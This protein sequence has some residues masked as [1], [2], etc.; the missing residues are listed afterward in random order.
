M[1]IKKFS[2]KWISNE[3]RKLERLEPKVISKL[4]EIKDLKTRYDMSSAIYNLDASDIA[5]KTTV[6]KAQLKSGAIERNVS[7]RRTYTRYINEAQ[8]IV[9]SSYSYVKEQLAIR[10]EAYLEHFKLISDEEY[11][12]AKGYLKRMNLKTKRKFF[13]SDK[14][15]ITPDYDSESW[16]KFIDDFEYSIDFAKLQ[17]FVYQEFYDKKGKIFSKYESMKDLDEED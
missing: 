14:F 16:R 1:K 2:P 9:K 10:Q 8:K 5:F 13:T 3:V 4:D 11:K 6:L 7:L 17:D 12:K 15:F